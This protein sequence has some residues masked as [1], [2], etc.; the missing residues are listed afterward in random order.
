MKYRSLQLTGDEKRLSA[1]M[2]TSLFGP[3]RLTHSMLGFLPDVLPL[4]W[5]PVGR[6]DRMIV[7]E[8]AGAFFVARGVLRNSED[9]PFDLVAYG[10]GRSI[11]ASLEHLLTIDPRPTH[12]SYVG[13]LDCAGL[14]IADAARARAITLGLPTLVLS[15]DLYR[16]M[17]AAADALG[18][19]EGW[20]ARPLRNV[21][22]GAANRLV[23]GLA[24]DLRPTVATMLQHGR[25]IPEEVLG[26]SEMRE[27]F[28][29]VGRSRPPTGR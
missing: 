29:E 3:G 21:S 15:S 16:A 12:I 1:W 19:P 5:E 17:L 11:A 22:A 4:A 2:K 20:P 9:P 24:E 23:Q 18:A 25:R 14:E 28:I 13:D 6:G 8:N 26:P 7:F 27:A 10:G